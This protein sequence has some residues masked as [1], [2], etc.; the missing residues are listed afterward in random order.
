MSERQLPTDRRSRFQ[1]GFAASLLRT[2]LLFSGIWWLQMSPQ[3]GSL[4][5]GGRSPVA[6]VTGPGRLIRGR[7]GGRSPEQWATGPCRPPF[8]KFRPDFFAKNTLSLVH[9]ATG[10]LSP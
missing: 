5:R 6:W 1:Q 2:P 9:W 8:V 3:G 10:G 4:Y 7:Q